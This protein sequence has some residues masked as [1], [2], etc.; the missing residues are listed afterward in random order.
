MFYKSGNYVDFFE[1]L[2]NFFFYFGD[3]KKYISLNLWLKFQIPNS[4]WS[5]V[6]G[7]QLPRWSVQKK[8]K[9]KE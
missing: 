3:L 2:R 7:F 9:K 4:K 8:E 6:G 1:I 5:D